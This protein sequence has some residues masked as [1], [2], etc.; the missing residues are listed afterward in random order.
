MTKIRIS[1]H[2]SFGNILKFTIA[3]ISMMIFASIYSV[4]DGFFISNFA[5]KEAFTAVN[6]IFPVIMIVAG[7]GFMF[8]TG[9]SA[10]VAAL[11][12]KKEDEKARK[13]FS[14]VVYS[15]FILGVVLSIAIFFLVEPIVNAFASVNETT[16]QSTIDNAILYGR[17]MIAGECLYILQN[18][19]QPFFSVAEKPGMGFLFTLIAGITNMLFDYIFI[20]VLKF[21]V[22]GAASASLMG[23][24]V[25]SVGPLLYFAVNK[26]N[27]IYLGKPEWNFGDLFKVLG[28]GSSEFVSNI[29]SSIISM[30]FN[31]QLLKYIGE[32]GVSA[33]GII[34]YVSFVFAAIF[35]GYSIG[36]SPVVSYNYGAENKKE[37]TSLFK[38]SAMLLSIA[39]VSMLVLSELLAKPFSTIFSSGSSTLEEIATNAMRIYSLSYLF[40]GFS[41]FG[42]SFFTALNNGLVS[43]IISLART[44]GFQLVSVLV[45]PLLMGVNGIWWSM[46]F[47]EVGSF[48]MSWIFIL[49]NQDK[50]GYF[51]KE[52]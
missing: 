20:G 51:S 8:G 14:M 32:D 31:I 9:G 2:F 11:F 38:K 3:P 10:F 48:I 1:D 41:I 46:V 6:L 21:G 16:S 4:V 23:M 44:L 26:K 43:A 5:S 27:Q 40:M 17:I 37:L 47:A 50:Y 36:I 34:M 13:A 42:S 19:F 49:T 30:V 22:A 45:F 28:N 18:T 39:G 52:K 33:Y 25:G 24:A 12:G 7:V 29:S 35:I 15:A